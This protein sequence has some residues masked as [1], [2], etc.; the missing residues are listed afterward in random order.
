MTTAVRT[1]NITVSQRLSVMACLHLLS[2]LKYVVSEMMLLNLRKSI[3]LLFASISSAKVLETKEIIEQSP[4][5]I[6]YFGSTAI[7][8]PT[9]K[10]ALV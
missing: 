10:R 6:N 7:L 9:K 4:D 8:L 5:Y 1:N 3:I 2:E